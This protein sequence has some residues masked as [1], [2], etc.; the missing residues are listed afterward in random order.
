MIV[1]IEILL[2]HGGKLLHPHLHVFGGILHLILRDDHIVIHA[3]VV[4]LHL[5]LVVGRPFHDVAG[6]LV[7]L[8]DA[9]GREHG[10]LPVVCDF[11]GVGLKG[12]VF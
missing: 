12:H 1:E 11:G 2:I 6:L 9:G 8:L 10:F 4:V 7:G 3:E 5:V